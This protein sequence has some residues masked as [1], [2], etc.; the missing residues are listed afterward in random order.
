[1]EAMTLPDLE[2]LKILGII[3]IPVVLVIAA[4]AG[5]IYL[6]VLDGREWESFKEAHHC[7]IVGKVSGSVVTTPIFGG[8]NGVS[9]GVST[10][11]S[12][13]GWQ[14]DDGITYWR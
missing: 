4:V 10:I 3:S 6:F 11:P 2:D 1:M 7:H 5:L 12:K 13:T 9:I 14:C 8:D